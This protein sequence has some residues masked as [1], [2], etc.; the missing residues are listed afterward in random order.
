[1]VV[2]YHAV[3]KAVPAGYLGVDIFFVISGYLITGIIR[4][5]LSD[6]TFSIWDFYLKRAKRLLPA[7]YVTLIATILVAPFF[8]TGSEAREFQTQ[9]LGAVSFT[10]NFV[11]LNQAGYFEGSAELKPLLHFWSLAI[12]EQYYLFVPFIFMALNRK[13]RLPVVFAIGVSSLFYCLVFATPDR[14]FYLLPSRAWELAIGSIAALAGQQLWLQRTARFMFYPSVLLILGLPFYEYGRSHPGLPAIAICVSTLFVILA[15]RSIFTNRISI[16]LFKLGGISYSLYLVHW[17]IFAFT[18]NTWIETSENSQPITIRLSLL[19]TAVALAVLLN[20]CIE[21]PFKS[22]RIV[23]K[24]Q[25][26]LGAF[27]ATIFVASF[28]TGVAHAFSPEKD[29][30]AMRRY[31]SGL[32]DQCA[33]TK[34]KFTVSEQCKTSESPATLI[35]G[36]SY[37]MHLVSGLEE[38]PGGIIQATRPLCGPFVDIAP[39]KG[40]AY[41]DMWAKD[42]LVFN[43]SVL[44]YL[45]REKSIKIVVLSSTFGTYV[46]G[47]RKVL[48]S[49]IAKS[50]SEVKANTEL[51]TASMKLLVHQIRETG[52]KVIVIAPPPRGLIDSARC[53]E[54]FDSEVFTWGS[55]SNCAISMTDYERRFGDVRRYLQ[56]LKQN[57]H[58]NV[59]AFDNLLCDGS[60][61][62]TKIDGV[63]LYRDAGHLS[64]E[65]SIV[66]AKA[67]HLSDLVL[68]DAD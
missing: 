29:Y 7:A 59:I 63:P 1:M 32:S 55:D 54:R 11:L 46:N 38:L 58:V 5:G 60:T 33:F 48:K 51:A 4:D 66:L 24:K 20:K 18:N 42:C 13:Y 57:A 50:F 41:N 9:V 28:S 43:Q 68:S 26:A 25:F 6:K 16:P 67:A 44:D 37:A 22:I 40:S 36:D 31:N 10:S 21:E 19:V 65:G 30:V 52:K 8:L 45:K 49:D 14:A 15:N 12:E 2:I 64:F 47:A 62:K 27:C 56:G 35:W 23:R 3:N 39:L 53:H 34:G 17:P 61:C